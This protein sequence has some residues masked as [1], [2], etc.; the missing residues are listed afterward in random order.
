MHYKQHVRNMKTA[1]ENPSTALGILSTITLVTGCVAY[2][3]PHSGAVNVTTLSYVYQ[4]P[5]NSAPPVGV[6]QTSSSA[7]QLPVKPSRDPNTPAT[8]S[9]AQPPSQPAPSGGVIV[10]QAP[11]PT[12]PE[13]IPAA[14][15]P[16]YQWVPG[17]WNWNGNTWIWIGGTWVVRPHLGAVWVGGRWARHGRGWVWVGG[18]WH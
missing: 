4:P 13:V 8:P 6:T 1:E 14:P 7:E 15:G 2:V 18:H 10:A 11:P 9:P 3:P 5:V 16:D 17:Y 12:Q